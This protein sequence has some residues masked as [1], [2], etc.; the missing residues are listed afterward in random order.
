MQAFL[1]FIHVFVLSFRY[2][3]S[4]HVHLGNTVVYGE[5][6]RCWQVSCQGLS[7]CSYTIGLDTCAC[8]GYCYSKNVTPFMVSHLLTVQRNNKLCTFVFGGVTPWRRR[9][10]SRRFQAVFASILGKSVRK[11]SI[12]EV[13][14]PIGK[15]YPFDLVIIRMVISRRGWYS[16][17]SQCVVFVRGSSTQVSLKSV[18]ESPVSYP[19]S[20]KYAYHTWR[21]ASFTIQTCLMM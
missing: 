7:G 20:T 14:I 2:E 16:S 11:K 18:N 15:V 19:V 6:M 17:H 10:M 4:Y 5:S 8:Y 13:S 3:F 1:C 21:P 12:S 9:D